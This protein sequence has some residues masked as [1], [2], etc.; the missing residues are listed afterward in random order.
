[1]LAIAPRVNPRGTLHFSS[2][3]D[4]HPIYQL[5]LFLEHRLSEQQ[6]SSAYV[7]V[8]V[9]YDGDLCRKG[10]PVSHQREDLSGPQSPLYKPGT[11]GASS[12]VEPFRAWSTG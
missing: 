10:S 3:L 12:Y 11:W 7:E 5:T 6:E 8:E 2:Y 1:M 9:N 4:N